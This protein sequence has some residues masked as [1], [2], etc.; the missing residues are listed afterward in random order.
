MSGHITKNVYTQ[1][2]IISS[3]LNQIANCGQFHSTWM[4]CHK[5]STYSVYVN[6][7]LVVAVNYTQCHVRF[8][9]AVINLR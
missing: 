4:F 1:S 3:V 9:L 5:N 8:L 6:S 2:S 7:A